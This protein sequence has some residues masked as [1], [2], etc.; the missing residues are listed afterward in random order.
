MHNANKRLEEL[1]E[2]R[3]KNWRK[4]L[5]STTEEERAKWLKVGGKLS[6]ETYYRKH[7]LEWP[8]KQTKKGA[9]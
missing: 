6:M 1:R 4:V 9:L 5:N 7:G 2:L 3:I 8:P